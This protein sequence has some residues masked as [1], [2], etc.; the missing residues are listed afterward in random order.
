MSFALGVAKWSAKSSQEI[1]EFHS[2]IIFRLYSS[3]IEDTPI[4]EGRLRGNWFPSKNQPSGEKHEDFQG[5]E[6]AA[7]QQSKARVESFLL[8]FNGSEDFEV[9]LTNNLPYAASIEYDGQSHTKAPEGMV[10]KNILHM[11]QKIQKKL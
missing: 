2:E 10:R 4:L 7:T 8:D 5:S 6:Q 11:V 3:V 9:F 1:K